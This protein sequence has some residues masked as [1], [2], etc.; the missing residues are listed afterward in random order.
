[1]IVSMFVLESRREGGGQGE[2]GS[3]GGGKGR[4][5]EPQTRWMSVN[6]KFNTVSLKFTVYSVKIFQIF[7]ILSTNLR[8]CM[9]TPKNES[10]I[11]NTPDL[12]W[13]AELDRYKETFSLWY[14]LQVNKQER[15]GFGCYHA[16]EGLPLICA[17]INKT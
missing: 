10:T 16:E 2:G 13:A 6:A 1:M 14:G 17:R 5:G 11:W 7:L 8:S 3:G 12:L 4:D 9:Y 15:Q